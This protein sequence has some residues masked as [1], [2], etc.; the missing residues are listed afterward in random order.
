[1][2]LEIV[3]TG[4]C[5]GVELVVRQRVSEL[6]AGGSK[7]IIETII[8]VIHLV[9]LEH[10]FQATFIETCVMGHEWDGGYQVTSIVKRQLIRE[11]HI[12]NLFLQLLPYLREHRSIVRIALAQ[13]MHPL[14]P[15]IVVV[16]LWLNKTIE[17]KSMAMKSRIMVDQILELYE[18]QWQLYWPVPFVGYGEYY[19]FVRPCGNALPFV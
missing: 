5:N 18:S 15:I 3:A 17:T 8:R 2:P 10:S 9:H 19:R 6:S 4:C 1:M 14:T 13:S 7:G 16:R 12:G 11:K